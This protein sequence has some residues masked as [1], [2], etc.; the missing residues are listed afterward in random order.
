MIG[1][2]LA[3]V[4]S[5][6]RIED[7][8]TDHSH[9]LSAPDNAPRSIRML[10]VEISNLTMEEALGQIFATVRGKEKRS[11]A[12][13]N[14]DCL[15]QASRNPAYS[16]VLSRQA[17]VFADGSGIRF[18]AR[19]RGQKVRDNVNGTDMLPLLCAQAA[20]EG[21]GIFLLGARQ[22]L[23]EEVARR[24]TAEHPGL[25]I[26][27]THHG[28]FPASET[29]NV[30][31]IINASGAHILLVAMGVPQQE[32]W[33]SRNL[34]KLSVNMVM[35]VGGLFDFYSGR[36]PRA[37]MWMRRSG[38]E[39]IYRLWQEPGRM[40]RRYILGNP[41]FVWRTWREKRHIGSG[42]LFP[43]HGGF[44][45]LR[46]R[47]RRTSWKLEGTLYRFAKRMLDM[48]LATAGLIALAP[49]FLVIA[50]AIKL[51]SPGP[52]FFSQ[53]RVGLKGQRFRM[54]KFRSMY[55]DAEA[56]RA[57]LLAQSDRSGMHF[58]MKHDPRITRVGRI[59][60]RAS[61]DELPQLLNVLAGSMS[62][63]GPR[64]NLE[65]E[66]A[67]YRIDEF[68]RLDSKPGITCIWQVSGRAE[69]PWERQVEMDLDYVYEPSLKQDINLIA[70]T[71]PAI[72]SGK[73]AY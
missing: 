10:G 55:I 31:D 18:A 20:K 73:G 42:K 57:A 16:R 44:A 50:A 56:R 6:H 59:I 32:L 69:V 36:I 63:V 39:W 5:E 26:S 2:G 13:V 47:I 11:F 64:P 3:M 72:L 67:R 61:I 14:A 27:G 9:A 40:W 25:L 1:T 46:G 70:K 48:L 4:S 8:M 65:S 60:R 35:G 24:M 22:G 19:M 29:Q 49:F 17:A 45:T 41:L 53:R 52:V 30:I 68:G 7:H 15:N 28:Y 66:V 21:H 23:A 38:T 62:I 51:E 12:F 37:P 33:I 34:E 58:K 54:W 71:L 43:W